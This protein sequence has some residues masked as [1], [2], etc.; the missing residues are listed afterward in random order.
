MMQ[1]VVHAGK[2]DRRITLQGFTNTVDDY[3]VPIPSWSNKATVWAELIERSTQEFV[4]AQG[5]QGESSVAFRIRHLDG[6]VTGDRV[7]FE[8]RTLNIKE[9]ATIGRKVGI[10]LRCQEIS[11]DG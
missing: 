10:E 3:G 5:A 4:R 1:T 7:L 6:I 8:G 11:S 2:M 9:I